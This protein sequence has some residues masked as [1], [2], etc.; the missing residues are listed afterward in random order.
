MRCLINRYQRIRVFLC[1]RL[2]KKFQA[3]ISNKVLYNCWNVV[4]ITPVKFFRPGNFG[5]VVPLVN[6]ILLSIL[7]KSEL[8]S[9]YFLNNL[10][11]RDWW[12]SSPRL[13]HCLNLLRNIL[14]PII[15][16][17]SKTPNTYCKITDWNPQHAT[18]NLK[19]LLY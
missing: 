17:S 16:V 12:T 18:K 10:L 19:N 14:F 5:V 4:S 8:I 2:N 15:I 6:K 3:E 11:S 9:T 13:P 1:R 7:W